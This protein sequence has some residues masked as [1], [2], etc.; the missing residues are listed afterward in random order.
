MFDYNHYFANNIKQLKNEE[1]YRVFALLERETKN[2]PKAKYF[3][4][5][6][7]VKEVTI[8]C[9]NDYLGQGCNINTIEAMCNTA[10]STGAGAGG[11]RNISGNSYYHKLLEDE[12][13][14]YHKKE[15]ALLFTSGYVANEAAISSLVK[16]LPNC[17]IFSDEKNHASIIV[18]IKSSSAKKHIFAHNN[19]QHLEELLQLYPIDTP[20]IIIFESVYSMDGNIGDIINITKLAKKYGALTYIDEVHAIGMY[21]ETGAG[22][23]QQ[24]G[25]EDKIDI[26][27]ATLGKAIGCVGG[28]VAANSLI[29]D[30]I[31]SGASGFIFTT[32]IPP[33]IAAASLASIKYLQSE[34]GAILRKKQQENVQYLKNLLLKYNL[35]VL[36]SPSH[37]IPLMVY[38]S[39]LCS[40]LSQ[41]LLDRYSIYIQ[42]I[43]Y[44]TV[45]KGQERLRITPTPFHSKEL[46]NELANILNSLWEELKIKRSA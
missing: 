12:L 14:N 28:Y 2:F 37:I 3:D 23:V 24:L 42:P 22:I 7:K 32:S 44:P 9:S 26:M 4:N 11:T 6:G 19:M 43:N 25:Y 16:A 20:K 39:A 13:A 41:I 17:I 31:R 5:T 29:I 38:D 8:W 35:P 36:N 1:R 10:Q 30:V 46:M 18:G 45:Q 40:K 33:A 15:N 27:Q 21:G 34:N